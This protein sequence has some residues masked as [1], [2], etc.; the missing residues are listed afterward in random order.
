MLNIER[1]SLI[2]K[3]LSFCV[4][5]QSLWFLLGH[6]HTHLLLVCQIAQVHRGCLAISGPS[7]TPGVCAASTLLLLITF[8]SGKKTSEK[9]WPHRF[10]TAQLLL[11]AEILPPCQLSVM[12]WGHEWHSTR[13]TCWRM[14]GF[15]EIYFPPAPF[16]F[17]INH[18]SCSCKLRCTIYFS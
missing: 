12:Q 5:Q 16:F 1:N 17:F 2:C 9:H 3:V 7:W 8:A 10:S 6:T 14:W 18:S 15:N 13:T 11:V 4:S